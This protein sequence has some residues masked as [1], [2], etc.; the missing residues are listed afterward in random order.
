MGW[1]PGLTWSWEHRCLGLGS[2]PA[3]QAQLQEGHGSSDM[4]P[5]LPTCLQGRSLPPQPATAGP[6]QSPIWSVGQCLMVHLLC[7][8]YSLFGKNQLKKMEETMLISGG[9]FA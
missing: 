1:C 8:K 3:W 7:F 9:W 2:R 4:L 6:L 5:T